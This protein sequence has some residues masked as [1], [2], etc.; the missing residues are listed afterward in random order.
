MPGPRKQL[1]RRRVAHKSTGGMPP[2]IPAPVDP[3]G[4]APGLTPNTVA[5]TRLAMLAGSG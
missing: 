4:N 3:L 2:A 1:T 5:S